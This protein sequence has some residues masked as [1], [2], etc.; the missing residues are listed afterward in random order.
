MCD[1]MKGIFCMVA[2][3]RNHRVAIL[4][5]FPPFSSQNPYTIANSA[6]DQSLWISSLLFSKSTYSPFSSFFTTFEL[7]LCGVFLKQVGESE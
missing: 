6:K 2:K 7:S 4:D 1:V 5:S 3:V